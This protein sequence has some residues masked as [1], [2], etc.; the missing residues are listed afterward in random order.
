ML[1]VFIIRN[2]VQALPLYLTKAPIYEGVRA[3]AASCG[4]PCSG[5]QWSYMFQVKFRDEI[6]LGILPE[7]LLYG[8][9]VQNVN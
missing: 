7:I 5:H 4:R 3:Y 8:M 6:G 9:T 1:L 2:N